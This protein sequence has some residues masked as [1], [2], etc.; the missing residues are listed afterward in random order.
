M[1]TASNLFHFL[2]RQVR[3]DIRKP[4]VLMVNKKLLKS[5][6]SASNLQEFDSKKSF[7]P[8]YADNLPENNIRKVLICSG[9]VYFDLLER[10][11]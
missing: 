2:R 9:Q 11:N 8:V 5:K 6:N 4:L 7:V 3:R 10:R 1:T